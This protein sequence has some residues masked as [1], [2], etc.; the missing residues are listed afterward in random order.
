M[1]IDDIIVLAPNIPTISTATGGFVGNMRTNFGFFKTDR[2]PELL[3]NNE[4]S[5]EQEQINY[6]PPSYVQIR[7]DRQRTRYTSN[8]NL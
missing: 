5:E 4:D 7:H 6:K 2:K 3:T 1:S 8:I